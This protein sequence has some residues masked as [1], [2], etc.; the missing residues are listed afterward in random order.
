MDRPGVIESLKRRQAA[1]YR[2]R[3][4]LR[5][6][7]RARLTP[8]DQSVASLDLSAIAREVGTAVTWAPVVRSDLV[9]GVVHDRCSEGAGTASRG[10]SGTRSICCNLPVVG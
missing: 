2:A 7:R 6:V 9:S 8:V 1:G 5:R 10:L 4:F 3:P